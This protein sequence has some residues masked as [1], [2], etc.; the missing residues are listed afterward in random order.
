MALTPQAS[1]TL[2]GGLPKNS[3]NTNS[4]QSPERGKETKMFISM[5]YR[6]FGEKLTYIDGDII[7]TEYLFLG[8]V[9]VDKQTKATQGNIR[10]QNGKD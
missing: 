8:N 1:K 10:G 6:L 7:V 3:A 2:Q 4:S 5:I 9:Y